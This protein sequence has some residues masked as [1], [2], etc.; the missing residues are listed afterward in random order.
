MKL[1]FV[2]LCIMTVIGCDKS[3]EFIFPKAVVQNL[4]DPFVL[5]AS[6][7]AYYM[8][9]TTTNMGGG[10]RVYKSTDLLK[11]ED[12][13]WAF[14]NRREN[15]AYKDF[16]AP[17][18]VERAG[19]FYMLYTARAKV[20]DRLHIGLAVSD[21]PLG[22]FEDKRG[23]PL[24]GLD[25]AHIDG[26][27]FIDSDNRVYMYYVRDVSENIVDGSRRSDIY[28]AELDSNFEL[29]GEPEYLFSPEQEWETLPISQGWLWNEAPFVV[30]NDDIYYMTYSGNP[31]FAFEYAIGLA[32][33]SSPNGPWVKYKNNPVVQ[34][35][36][37]QGV[38]GTGHNCIFKSHDGKKTY[39]AYHV[40]MDPESGGGP[41]KILISQ[42][43]FENGTIR[44]VKD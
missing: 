44:L 9:G 26:S 41:R 18:V 1:F 12:E 36:R 27:V 10:F 31:F 4:A 5:T 3:G 33:S 11:W 28:V 40:H 7:G 17:E 43:R 8:Y 22:P 16:W 39:M 13:G 37:E 21:S 29:L 19:H 32:T 25:Y 2:G 23:S 20:T 24:L 42:I 15:W 30:K 38:S 6:D 14:S 35:S 34:G